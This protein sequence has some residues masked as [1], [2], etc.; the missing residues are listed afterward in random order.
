MIA[1]PPHPRVVQAAGRERPPAVD[2]PVVAVL[3]GRRRPR[4]AARTSTAR[5]ARRR[6]S[7]PA[8]RRAGVPIT[9]C[10]ATPVAAIQDVDEQPR[11]TSAI[12]S[13]VRP[14]ARLESAVALGGHEPQEAGVA[15]APPCSRPGT[16]PLRSAR[17]AFGPQRRNDLRDA[18]RRRPRGSGSIAWPA[19]PSRSWCRWATPARA[20][21]GIRAHPDQAR[22]RDSMLQVTSHGSA[23][24][25]RTA[26]VE[27]LRRGRRPCSMPPLST[28]RA[29][30]RPRISTCSASGSV[31][32]VLLRRESTRCDATS[33]LEGSWLSGVRLTHLTIGAVRFGTETRRRARAARLL[34]R[35]PRAWPDRSSRCAGT[36]RVS[37]SARAAPCSR[38]SPARRCPD[39]ATDAAQ[40]CI[41]IRRRSLDA[42]LTALLGRSVSSRVDFDVALRPDHRGAQSW[43]ATPAAAPDRARSPGRSIR[44]RRPRTEHLERLLMSGLVLAQLNTSHRRARASRSRHPAAH[45]R[46][47]RALIQERADEP[48]D[49]HRP[50]ESRRRRGPAPPAGLPRARRHVA[51]GSTSDECASIARAVTSPRPRTRH[52]DRVPL[53]LPPTPVASPA[54]TASSSASRRPRRGAT[55]V[56]AEGVEPPRS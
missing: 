41:K 44:G 36:Q 5:R 3:P 32:D 11:P 43:L 1:P 31:L 13:H 26:A 4:T 7:R 48:A 51:D 30:P 12:D 23:F 25:V 10:P 34:P 15:S 52:R 20:S 56:R 42:E 35:Q 37:T 54:R 6:R 47:G 9:H 21:P 18:L 16:R 8:P 49:A 2:D 19:H 22:R 14:P 27:L 53:G 39:G 45:G 28:L 29:V 24:D 40:L 55:E 17:S 50:R 33:R 38:P 46:Q